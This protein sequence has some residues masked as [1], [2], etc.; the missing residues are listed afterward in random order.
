MNNAIGLV[1]HFCH[2]WVWDNPGGIRKDRIR[3]QSWSWWPWN[4]W[5]VNCPGDSG[6]K[7]E[8]EA[9]DVR[10]GRGIDPLLVG[11]GLVGPDCGTHKWSA[12]SVFLWSLSWTQIFSLLSPQT[13][14]VTTAP[15]FLTCHNH[16][17]RIRT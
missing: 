5:E 7:L 16:T 14:P 3:W 1:T 11:G 13:L 15:W 4:S 9:R 8:Q 2:L 12:L 17:T 10:S 6:G